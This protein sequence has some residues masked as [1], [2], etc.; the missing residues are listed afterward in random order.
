MNLLSVIKNLLLFILLL[1][2]CKDNLVDSLTDISF[3]PLSL[4][5]KWTYNSTQYD[6]TGAV[7]DQGEFS[8]SLPSVYTRDKGLI[9][10]FNTPFWFV[11]NDML[12]LQNKIYGLYLV[13]G[14]PDGAF[15]G[16]DF[17]LY[18]YPVVNGEYYTRGW[19]SMDTTYVI[20]TDKIV[21]C[22]AG[23]FK[24][25]VYKRYSIDYSDY[26]LIRVLGYSL[27]YVSYGTGK[28]KK[29]YFF[30]K[31]NGE[32]FKGIEYSLKSYEFY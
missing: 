1:N 13:L 3:Y 31:S 8:E 19:R 24:S 14:S 6:S 11:H 28:I 21:E 27:D 5:N 26:P 22:Q 23:I 18:K 16:E 25:I 12:Y 30:P 10:E 32:F 15:F 4:G 17:L 7:I 9:Y 29:E 20:S 2:S